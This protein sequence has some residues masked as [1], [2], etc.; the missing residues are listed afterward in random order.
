MVAQQTGFSSQSK[1]GK[2]FK[3][4]FGVTPLEYR[5]RKRVC[6]ERYEDMK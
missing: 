1:F 3:D 2:A 5:R 6:P 4:Y